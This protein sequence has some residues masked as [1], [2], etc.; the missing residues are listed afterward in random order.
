[1]KKKT[2]GI[3]EWNPE[4]K[5]VAKFRQNIDINQ[6]IDETEFVP[7]HIKR[8]NERRALEES[9]MRLAK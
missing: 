7:V 5:D 3:I 2:G 4:K 1:M 9:E 8:E 6:D